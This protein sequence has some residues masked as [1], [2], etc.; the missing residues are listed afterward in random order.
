M[1][2][3]QWSA[4]VRDA[5]T[6]TR[7]IMIVIILP[8]LA[9]PGACQPNNVANP[10]ADQAGGDTAGGD[11]PWWLTD[12]DTGGDTTGGDIM[13]GDTT[14]GDYYSPNGD[15]FLASLTER[16]YGAWSGEI[17]WNTETRMLG[18]IFEAPNKLT[19]IINPWGPARH[20]YTGTYS[21]EGCCRLLLSVP[22]LIVWEDVAVNTTQLD[23]TDSLDNKIT[24]TSGINPP[25]QGLIGSLMV[26]SESDK[27]L[28]WTTT[29]FLPPRFDYKGLLNFL[30][31]S[32]PNAEPI[33]QDLVWGVGDFLIDG[34]HDFSTTDLP[35]FNRYGGTSCQATDHFA[36]AYFGSLDLPAGFT[37]LRYNVGANGVDDAGLAFVEDEVLTATN[38]DIAVLCSAGTII[39]TTPGKQEEVKLVVPSEGTFPFELVYLE[40][41]GNVYHNVE[42]N[43]GAGYGPI[44]LDIISPPQ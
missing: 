23:Y 30:H 44:P 2:M 34:D 29:G 13:G 31:H 16:V 5:M 10:S 15:S 38:A 22:E 7:H 11:E 42:I 3:R 9:I 20:E 40:R 21:S 37:N 18:V 28:I 32:D 36:V 27:D 43:L 41:E 33:C 19:Y 8:L 12:Q 14:G 17:P 35:G 6:T 24:M 25:T 26:Y 1:T 39:N 4:A